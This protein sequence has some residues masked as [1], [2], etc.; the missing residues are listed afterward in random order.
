MAV[1]G[2]GEC[3]GWQYPVLLLALAVQA[4]TVLILLYFNLALVAAR[5]SSCQ[6][7]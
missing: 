2:T 1:S 6:I 4:S 5:R 3:L 7:R